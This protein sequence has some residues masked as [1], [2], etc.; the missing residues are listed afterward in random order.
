MPLQDS[1]NKQTRSPRRDVK[2]VLGRRSRDRGEGLS[3]LTPRVNDNSTLNRVLRES[4]R[5]SPERQLLRRRLDGL[6][7]RENEVDGDGNCQF[8]A[9][10]DQLYGSP[11]RDAEVR[12]NIVEHLRSNSS[13]YSAFVPES[14]DAYI[15]IM[16]LDGNWGDHLTLIAA[17]NV[18]GLEIR[19]YT[20]YDRNWERVIRPTDDGNI[21]RVIQLSF[22][23]ELHYN[24]VHPITN[25]GQN[26]GRDVKDVLGRRSRDR[27]E[28][29]ST[30]TPRVNDS[31]TLNRVLRESA[32]QSPERQLLRRRLDGLGLRENEV[33]GDGNCQFRA[34]ADQLYGSPDH[35][36]EVRANIV[37]HLR[38]NSSRYS[39]FVPDS[40]DTYIE[41]MGRD[42]NWGDHLTLQAA[43]NVYGLEIRVYTSYDGN[44]EGVFRPT[45]DGNIRRVIQLSFY[46]E[47]H[48][49]SVYP[50]TDEDLSKN[51]E[52]ETK[53]MTLL[54]KTSQLTVYVLKLKKGKY[55]VGKTEQANFRLRSHFNGEGS[56]WTR[57]YKPVKVEKLIPNCD[58]FD[59]DKYTKKC[60]AKYGIESVRGGSFCK[61][62]LDES[63]YVTLRKELYSAQDKCFNCGGHH[64][65]KDCPQG[66]GYSSEESECDEIGVWECVVC[67]R[68]YNTPKEVS[69]C[70]CPGIDRSLWHNENKKRARGGKCTR[71]LRDTHYANK[72]YA[73][74]DINGKTINDNDWY[75]ESSHKSESEDEEYERECRSCGGDI[76]NRPL[77]FTQCLD[78]WRDEKGGRVGRGGRGGRAGRAGRA[79][80]RGRGGWSFS[81]HSGS[82][83]DLRF[84]GSSFTSLQGT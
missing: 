50:N 5:Q 55:Y 82:S 47:L 81:T 76:S 48:Y 7:L 8:R 66:K 35:Y 56:N 9:I 18:Y 84:V 6:G 16:G 43:S 54:E 3:T 52:E 79:S 41:N 73:K 39:A 59:E 17:S 46:A 51:E 30:L 65:I 57:K 25:E 24:S 36:A 1:T 11:E 33:D 32:R 10:A 68:Q 19:V 15:E 31:S 23:A 83:L 71:C 44:W 75:C 77:N 40:Y 45:D 78:C 64:F 42:G 62:I 13:R 69:N 49:N 67:E 34:I 20:S 4:A 12:A 26:P 27:G 14:Y 60:M 70:T 28:G 74:T 38:S 61:M 63:D 22:Y 58:A 2:D 21:R 53:K 72:C 29:L 80:R 37:E